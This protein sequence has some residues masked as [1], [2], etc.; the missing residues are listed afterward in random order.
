VSGNGVAGLEGGGFGSGGF[1]SGADEAAFASLVAGARE[2]ADQAGEAAGAA[3]ADD[4]GGE[5]FDE[6]AVAAL[7][8]ETA[9]VTAPF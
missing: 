2:P 1:G 9:S 3:G 7:A 5:M 8:E 4:P 6:D